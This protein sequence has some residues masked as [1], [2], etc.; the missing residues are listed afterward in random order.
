M[1]VERNLAC[2]DED[3]VAVGGR[4]VRRREDERGLGEIHFPRD[5]SHLDGREARRPR[6]HRERIAGERRIGEDV[7]PPEIEE[8]LR[9]A[10]DLAPRGWGCALLILARQVFA[11]ADLPRRG[12]SLPPPRRARRPDLQ[13]RAWPGPE[14]AHEV[15]ESVIRAMTPTPALPCART[16]A[17]GHP[18][19]PAPPGL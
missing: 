7:D 4:R 19:S 8:T 11:R 10:R 9:H 13:I 18:A 16:L 2:G 5:S 1:A 12:T 6:E 15:P 3:P 14:R 17:Q